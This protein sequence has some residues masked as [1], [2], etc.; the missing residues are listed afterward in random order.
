MKYKAIIFDL[1]G[2]LVKGS[3]A[4]YHR[5]LSLVAQSLRIDPIAFVHLW[6]KLVDNLEHHA[7]DLHELLKYISISMAAKHNQQEI[8]KAAEIMLNETAKSL[9]PQPFAL[10]T[11]NKLRE[12]KYKIGLISNCS[13]EVPTL[14]IKT[15][16][17]ELVDFPIFSCS[18]GLKKPDLNIYLLTCEKLSVMPKECLYVGDGVCEELRGASAAGMNPVLI[19]FLRESEYTSFDVAVE[20]WSG[21]TIKS[22][23]EI[24]NLL[25]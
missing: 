23:H 25:Q 6:K 22:L 13:P 20:Y 17:A 15:P 12:Q 8:N 10:S 18:V 19:R 3:P 5:A 9:T 11:L 14:W 1:F 4:N 2:T 24:L 7:S 21:P 16:L